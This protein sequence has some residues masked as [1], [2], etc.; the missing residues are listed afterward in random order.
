MSGVRAFWDTN[1]FIYMYSI[2]ELEKRQL[3]LSLLVRIKGMQNDENISS[4]DNK[5]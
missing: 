5:K 1:V 2:N 3:S 4:L